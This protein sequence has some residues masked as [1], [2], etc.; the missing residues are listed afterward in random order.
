[1][2][3]RSPKE[4]DSLHQ[5]QVSRLSCIDRLNM[6]WNGFPFELDLRGFKV[7]QVHLHLKSNITKESSG[8]EITCLHFLPFLAI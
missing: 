6:N 2:F 3:T 7:K 1:M 8:Q 5:I 4:T